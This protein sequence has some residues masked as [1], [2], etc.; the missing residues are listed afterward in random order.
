LGENWWPLGPVIGWGHTFV[1]EIDHLLRAI[2][3]DEVI[4]PHSA[5]FKNRYRANLVDVIIE[6]AETRRQLDIK[7]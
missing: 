5:T 7:Y 3:N 2:I 1:H 4:T 6:S